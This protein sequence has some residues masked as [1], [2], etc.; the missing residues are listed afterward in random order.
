VVEGEAAAKGPLPADSEPEGPEANA[1]RGENVEKSTGKGGKPR[2]QGNNEHWH[3]GSRPALK[4]GPRFVHADTPEEISDVSQALKR[5]R[6][7]SWKAEGDSRGKSV[8]GQFPRSRQGE[9]EVC[10]T[11]E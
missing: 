8:G 10:P 5:G 4:G 7:R 2:G 6:G 9:K 1:A 11:Q 3:E